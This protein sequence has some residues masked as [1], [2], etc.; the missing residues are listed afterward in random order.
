M[1]ILARI[2]HPAIIN[3][4]PLTFVPL[5]SNILD[6]STQI[7]RDINVLLHFSIFCKELLELLGFV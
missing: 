7:R 5:G 4:R 1:Q 6:K 3:N 2:L